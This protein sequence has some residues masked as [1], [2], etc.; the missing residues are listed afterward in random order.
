MTPLEACCTFED[1]ASPPPSVADGS[2][3]PAVAGGG[4]PDRDTALSGGRIA[5]GHQSGA[6]HIC[7]TATSAETVALVALVSY[8]YTIVSL[9]GGRVASGGIDSNVHVWDV[10]IIGALGATREAHM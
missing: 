9:R 8:V 1:S 2:V 5:V 4:A 3:S 7:D 6:L 10:A